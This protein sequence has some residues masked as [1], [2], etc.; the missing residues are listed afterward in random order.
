M[1]YELTPSGAGWTFIPIYSLVGGPGG[2][3]ASSLTIDATGNL[4]GTAEFD[5]A[6]YDGSVFRLTRNNGSWTYT[7]LYDFTGGADGANPVGAV[8]VDAGG[9][10]YGTTTYGGSGGSCE[11]GNGCGVAWKITP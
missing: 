11:F 1:V 9:N 5:G 4:Y 3:S 2:G 6:H 8:A 7:D 10:V